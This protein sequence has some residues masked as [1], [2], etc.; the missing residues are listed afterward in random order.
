MGMCRYEIRDA[1]LD[2]MADVLGTDERVPTEKRAMF[3]AYADAKKAEEKMENIF[4]EAEKATENAK[5]AEP[6]SSDD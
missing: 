4:E 3:K 5:K 2:A 6:V 1:V